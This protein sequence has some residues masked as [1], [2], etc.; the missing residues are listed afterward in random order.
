V[1]AAVAP[2]PH[3]F[4]PGR[5]LPLIVRGDV[6]GFF[7]LAL[8]NLVQL[9]LIDVLCRNV[10]GM[11][12]ELLRARVLPGAAVSLLVG[13]L[14][15]AWQA[16]R[17]A[18]ATGRTD[19]CAI[20]YGINTV[21]LF[22]HVF[23]IMLP[24][25]LAAEAAG[26]P[27]PVRVAWQAGLV[28]CLASGLIELACAPVAERVRRATP[29]AALLSTLA[30]IALGFISL[31]FLFR[32]F[33][34]PIV[35]L[36]TLG[37][38]LLAYFGGVR[39]RGGLPSGLI[40]VTLGTLL[41]WVT[42]IAPVGDPPGA[43]TL[44]LPVSALGDLAT[45]LAG[46]HLLA[47]LSVIVPMGLFN[48]VGS[49]QNI[50]SAEA[51]GDRYATAPSLAVNGLGSVAAALFG[52]CFPT[53]I[54]I[55]H[56]GWKTMGARSGYSVLNGLFTSAICLTGTVGHIAW[57]VPVDAGLAI[58]LWIGIVISAQAFSATPRA[59]APAVV[60][61]IL[62]GVAAWGAL[63]AKNGL[64]A[65][66]IGL[67]GGPPFGPEIVTAFQTSDTWIHGAFALEQGFIFTAMILS[68]A[69]VCL[70]ERTFTRAAL[71]CLLGAGLSAL[72]LVH[73][74]RFTPGDTAIA[75]EPAWA[76]A[77]GY[78][79]MAAWFLAARWITEPGEPH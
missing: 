73:S 43:A 36:P 34:H 56:P 49:L 6:D 10:L 20:P 39:L 33:A 4:Q 27:D 71:W 35:G 65:A 62:P 51:A 46:H 15:Y 72:G 21:S 60:M 7:G 37:I 19:V 16:R 68:A 77:V 76:W 66:G 28:A 31:G 23:L 44:Y 47:Y 3:G 54:Y 26:A 12:P 78:A 2:G 75:L 79:G 40:A 64:R 13:N 45:G 42:G 52:S 25:K 8:D 32:A 57:A 11:S 61:G 69:T 53:T 59:H 29:R 63:M 50:E 1:S 58:V 38:V 48:V 74:Y 55:G 18:A 17:L 22:G 14:F 41:A 30:G 24:A 67:P 9:L 70:I 5:R